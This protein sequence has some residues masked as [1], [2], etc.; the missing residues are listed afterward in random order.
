MN[1][2]VK[3]SG[4]GDFSFPHAQT[5]SLISG[6][7]MGS[8]SHSLSPAGSCIYEGLR[9]FGREGHFSSNLLLKNRSASCFIS[10]GFV[11]QVPFYHNAMYY[12]PP[13]VVVY[14]PV[15]LIKVP[16]NDP[17]FPEEEPLRSPSA[18]APQS[19]NTLG[20]YLICSVF[21]LPVGNK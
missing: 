2:N 1:L 13:L 5:A 21:D 10:H 14:A 20:I 17:I 9:S 8:S 18:L 15:L 3:P 19:Q 16:D 12:V 11:F 7:V 4:P 6:S